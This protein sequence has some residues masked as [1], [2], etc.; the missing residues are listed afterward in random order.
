M[1]VSA[2]DKKAEDDAKTAMTTAK[3]ALVLARKAL[4]DIK[5]DEI[6][7]STGVY[8]P[9]TSRFV[10]DSTLHGYSFSADRF[11]FLKTNVIENFPKVSDCKDTEKAENLDGDNVHFKCKCG[12]DLTNLPTFKFT[13]KG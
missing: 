11:T 2:A 1:T 8:S 6:V 10:F 4:E 5:N 13:F 12:E 3:D 7:K 9:Q